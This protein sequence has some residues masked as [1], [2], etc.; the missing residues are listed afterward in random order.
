MKKKVLHVINSLTT[1]GAEILLVNSVSPGGQ[2][3]Y[4]D[5]YLLSPLKTQVHRK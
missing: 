1:G 3:Q 2:Q 5:N 4:T